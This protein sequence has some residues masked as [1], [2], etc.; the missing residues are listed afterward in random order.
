MAY[1]VSAETLHLDQVVYV[2]L[3]RRRAASVS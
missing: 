2:Q 3:F 1:D